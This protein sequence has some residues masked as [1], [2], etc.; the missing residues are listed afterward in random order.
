M[1]AGGGKASS[2][3]GTGGGSWEIDATTAVAEVSVGA[4]GVEVHAA[5]DATI[6]PV[7]NDN[8]RAVRRTART[9]PNQTI[10]S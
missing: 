10:N 6:N 3:G 8:A 5:A 9:S 7:K 1:A 4:V 2:L